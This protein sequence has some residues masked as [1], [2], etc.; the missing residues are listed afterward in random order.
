MGSSITSITS[1]ITSSI[2]SSITSSISTNMKYLMITLLTVM[3]LL[4]SS[5][6]APKPWYQGDGL[7]DCA[8]GL[9]PATAEISPVKC[10]S[11]PTM[12]FNNGYPTVC[13]E[14]FECD[15]AAA[16]AGEGDPCRPVEEE[17]H[18]YEK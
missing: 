16:D 14:G 15:A 2:S 4:N 11:D 9:C 1:S 8:P 13:A 10:S 6:A 18:G 5:N 7:P 12:Y 17:D 3:I